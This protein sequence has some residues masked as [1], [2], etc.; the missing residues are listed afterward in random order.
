MG[1]LSLSYTIQ[2]VI[3][4][5]CTEFQNPRCSSSCEIFDTNFTMHYIG[6]RDGK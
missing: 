1:M 3:P 4:N 6:V 5:V 2:I